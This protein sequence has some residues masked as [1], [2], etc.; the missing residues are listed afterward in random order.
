MTSKPKH[1]QPSK[2][3]TLKPQSAAAPA[4]VK[5]LQDLKALFSSPDAQAA[6]DAAIEKA[7]EHK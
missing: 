6:L 1:Q 4:L 7:K 5:S 3:T 2:P